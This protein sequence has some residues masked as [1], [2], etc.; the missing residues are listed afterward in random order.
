MVVVNVNAAVI[1]LMPR[2]GKSNEG[3]FYGYLESTA[4]G[5][6]ND[7]ITITNCS[8]VLVAN[9]VDSADVLETMTYDTNIITMTT[10]AATAVSG[11][12]VCQK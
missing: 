11:L 9:L 5:K 7:T 10:S 6:Q 4:R 1:E 8:K 3:Y 12:V 2:G